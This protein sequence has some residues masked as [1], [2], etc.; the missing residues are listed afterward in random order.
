M[1]SFMFI[2]EN[3]GIYKIISKRDGKYYP[4]SSKHLL[5]RTRQNGRK[6][7]HFYSLRR[8]SHH[9]RHLQRAY[10]KYGEKN[11]EFVIIKNNI[12][13]DRLL[14]EEQ[15]LLDIARTEPKMCYTSNFIAGRVEMTKSLRKKMSSSRKLLFKNGY[16]SPMKGKKH[17]P[18]TKLRMSLASPIRK[19]IKQINK[20][21]GK[22]IRIWS[23][24][25]EAAKFFKLTGCSSICA[26]LHGENETSCGFVWQYNDGTKYPKFKKKIRVY[27][28]QKKVHQ[29]DLNTKKIIKTWT[30]LMSAARSLGKRSCCD[31][32]EVCRGTRNAAFGFK[33]AYA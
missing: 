8:G 5:Y 21:T 1:E 24:I 17:T 9:C 31:I 23:T 26:A 20:D 16:T 15:K 14:V 12:P 4:G 7:E 27:Y 29:I 11:F 32:T 2:L 13:E 33:W 30:S 25:T 3:S 28:N 19:S 18:L 6:E 22:L 10:N